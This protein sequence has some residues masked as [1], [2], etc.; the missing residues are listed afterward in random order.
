L[1]NSSLLLVTLY[2]C[3]T[4]VKTTDL[5]TQGAGVSQNEMAQTAG[6]LSEG[7]ATVSAV[8][9]LPIP[10]ASFDADKTQVPDD[11]S[12]LTLTPAAPTETPIDLFIAVG[13]NDRLTVSADHGKTW[14]EKYTSPVMVSGD[15]GTFLE[16][17]RGNGTIIA[18]AG[19]AASSPGTNSAYST[20]NG[21]TWTANIAG[22]NSGAHLAFGNGF[23]EAF[24]GGSWAQSTDGITWSAP[25][26]LPS[27]VC[28]YKGNIRG[29]TFGGEGDKAIFIAWGGNRH[30]LTSRDGTT[31]E[32]EVCGIDG[33]GTGAA[34]SI[35]H[36]F[37]GN[38]KFLLQSTPIQTSTDGIHWTDLTL[39][40]GETAA[41]KVI[42]FD[43][44][45]WH[46]RYADALYTSPDLE[47]WTLVPGYDTGSIIPT[48]VAVDAQ[49]T[50]AGISFPDTRWISTNDG[51]NFSI[52][53]TGTG[54]RLTGIT[55]IP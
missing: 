15:G 37:Y 41:L 44:S 10:K 19:E 54:D 50:I 14:E 53:A 8:S 2:A 49:G 1:I 20:D 16:V 22:T 36:L 9:A 18:M 6:P 5:R 3:S 31:W 42:Y 26:P 52:T 55:Y 7:T 32:N 12:L 28:R 45:T 40:S 47:T 23:F 24:Y 51:K 25:Q 17:V 43:Q 39:P 11:S 35:S 27:H 33:A 34:A 38:G 13:A 30:M 21:Q 29:L 48:S 46:F 4:E